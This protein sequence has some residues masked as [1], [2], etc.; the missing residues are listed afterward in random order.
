MFSQE[1]VLISMVLTLL[2][3]G[4]YN[5]IVQNKQSQSK[6]QPVTVTKVYQ[7]IPKRKLYLGQGVLLSNRALA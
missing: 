5:P 7:E 4:I 3:T 1:L 6:T 2:Y